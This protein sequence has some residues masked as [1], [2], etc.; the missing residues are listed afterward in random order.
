LE[1][2]AS[3]AGRSLTQEIEHRIERS[4]DREEIF[5]RMLGERP[6]LILLLSYAEAVVAA[7]ELTGKKRAQDPFTHR[8][9]EAARRL[10]DRDY[11]PGF[12]LPPE[13]EDEVE[14]RAREVRK[15]T[16]ARLNPGLLSERQGEPSDSADDPFMRAQPEYRDEGPSALQVAPPAEQAA[17]QPI[18]APTSNSDEP[19]PD[20][21]P[22]KGRRKKPPAT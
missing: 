22:A 4:F 20:G 3:A 8:V 1:N 11:D 14:I 15:I 16:L 6:N 13:R 2:A 10:L 21:P 9:V 18:V 5:A 19:A 12:D 7:E 17:W